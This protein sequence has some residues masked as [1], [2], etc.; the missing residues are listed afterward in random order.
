MHS[1]TCMIHLMK[2]LRFQ[3]GILE[4]KEISTA[5]AVDSTSPQLII[6]NFAIASVNPLNENQM[7]KVKFWKLAGKNE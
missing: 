5:I 4:N 6:Y 2:F 3:A 7:K 1:S